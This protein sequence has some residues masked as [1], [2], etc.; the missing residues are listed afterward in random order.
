QRFAA[1]RRQDELRAA[2][3]GENCSA[4]VVN[5]Q[6]GAVKVEWALFVCVN[7]V[8]RVHLPG[9][10]EGTSDG[11][12]EVA[13]LFDQAIGRARGRGRKRQ[14]RTDGMRPDKLV[15]QCQ[16]VALSWSQLW[17]PQPGRVGGRV[18]IEPAL[19][20]VQCASAQRSAMALFGVL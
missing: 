13:V 20:G 17:Q 9:R 4:F 3:V 19:I 7:K 12:E 10:L 5:S 15:Y 11:L 1:Q 8:A 14:D 18:K 6:N 16:N 2:H